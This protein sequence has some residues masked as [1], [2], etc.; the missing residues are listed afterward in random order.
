MGALHRS[1]V[2]P[3][4]DARDRTARR[5]PDQVDAPRCYDWRCQPFNLHR[6]GAVRG[7]QGFRPAIRACQ[8]RGRS[9]R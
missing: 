9:C 1:R 4:A 7:F 5:L 3:I 2:P 8:L 6:R